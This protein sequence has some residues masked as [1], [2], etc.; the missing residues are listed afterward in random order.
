MMIIIAQLVILEVE[1]VE[2]LGQLMLVMH[3][4]VILGELL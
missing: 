4:L 3:L 1:E 2:E